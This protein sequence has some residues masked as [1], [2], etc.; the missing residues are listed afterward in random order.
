MTA[1]S[2]LYLLHLPQ[3]SLEQNIVKHS[4]QVPARKT[5]AY[6]A[7]LPREAHGGVLIILQG[8]IEECFYWQVLTLKW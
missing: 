3:L 5:D 1:E 8:I 6:F 7:Y 2:V 4:R